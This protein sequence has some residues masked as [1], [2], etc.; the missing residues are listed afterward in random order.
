MVTPTPSTMKPNQLDV[1]TKDL[2]YENFLE[3][4]TNFLQFSAYLAQYPYIFLTLEVGL[5]VR[6]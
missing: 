3:N 1:T 5:E 4:L 6:S 2:T